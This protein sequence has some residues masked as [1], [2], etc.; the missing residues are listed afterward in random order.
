[1][2]N[3]RTSL[4]YRVLLFFLSP[5]ALGY[6]V[7]RSLKDG[8][9][10]Y[11]FQR[12][13]FFHPCMTLSPVLVHCASVGEFMA[14]KPLL[15][16]LYSC[17]TG[18]RLVIST[19]TPTA[20]KLVSALSHEQFMHVYMPLD[21]SFAVQRFLSRIRPSCVLIL[22]TEIWPT[23]IFQAA[24][25]NITTAIVNGRISSKTLQAKRM[26][27]NEYQSSL[28]NLTVILARSDEDRQKFLHLGA[29]RH[30]THNVGNLKYA[31]AQTDKKTRPCAI[32]RPYFLAV[33]THEDEELQLLEHM[34]LLKE[35]NYLLVLAPRYP[36]RGK[37]LHQQLKQKNFTVAL[38]SRQDRITDLTEVYVVDTLG[39][40]DRYFHEAV[41]VFVGGSLVPRGGHNILEPAG[42]GKCTI[43]G[44]HMDNFSLEIKELLN[45]EG[46]VQVSGNRQLGVQLAGLVHDQC[47]RDRLGMNA[48]RF[49]KQK[50]LIL[51]N[52]MKFLQPILEQ[53]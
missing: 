45:A 20:A 24:K 37:A 23:L 2:P 18:H 1:M 48:L 36:K 21:Y 15:D 31:A 53:R 52:Y 14:A 44:P 38:R 32:Q 46:I 11:F 51:E 35:N 7:Y 22:E 30:A 50:A 28:K 33:S 16:R 25:R 3:H 49:V 43:V 27:G 4:R 34:P 40:L 39:E 47:T 12:L 5:A 13:G 26:L 29:E 6:I 10:R 41:L 42:F 19:N 9:W 17:N 8:G